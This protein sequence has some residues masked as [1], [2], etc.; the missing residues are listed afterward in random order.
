MMMLMLARRVD[1]A[2]AAFSARVIGEPIGMEL[3]GKQLGIVGMGNVGRCLAEAA[4]GM[5][6]KV[7]HMACC[8]L[9]RLQLL[10]VTAQRCR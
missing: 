7:S 5:G 4:R 6:M 8:C 9:C 2:R 3:H 1:A 10:L